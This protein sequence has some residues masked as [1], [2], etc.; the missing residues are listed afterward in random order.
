MIR[1]SVIILSV[2]PILE[3]F[4]DFEAVER[5]AHA[6]LDPGILL[7]NATDPIAHIKRDRRGGRPCPIV[8]GLV[9]VAGEALSESYV[10]QQDVDRRSQP[11]IRQVPKFRG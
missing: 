6:A 11:E 8:E 10:P 2:R 4:S 1:G 9:Y 7:R 3:V 5:S